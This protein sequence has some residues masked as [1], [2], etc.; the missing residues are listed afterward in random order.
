MSSKFIGQQAAQELDEWLMDPAKGGFSVDQLMELAGLSV[1]QA[2][3]REYPK[4]NGGRV[5]VCAGPGNN[6]G[7]GLVAARHL[8]HFGYTV[9]VFYPKPTDKPLY[10]NLTTQ[11]K[12]L[13]IPLVDSLDA[14][15]KE[16]DVVVDALFGFSFKGDVRA[17]FDSVLKT[18]QSSRLPIV[19]IDIPS[20]WDVEKGNIRS[21]TLQ[22]STLVSLSVPKVGV[23]DF[24]GKHYLGGRF[25]PPQL[26]DRLGF[27]VP[28]YEGCEQCVDVTGWVREV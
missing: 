14:A 22:P 28:R 21:P 1:A 6:G 13:D 9:R 10:K 26:A 4:E 3:A 19:S 27:A 8:F 17:P 5:V 20:G 7:D 24:T 15:L 25:I 2:V 11:L 18:L 23:R 12:S 16:A